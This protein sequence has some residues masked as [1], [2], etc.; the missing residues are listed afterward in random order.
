MSKPATHSHRSFRPVKVV[1]HPL[2]EIP[3]DPDRMC[4]RKHR[5]HDKKDAVTAINAFEKGRARER[6]GRPEWLREYHC[7]ICN[8]W[9]LT[10]GKRK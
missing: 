2:G 3:I 6:H 7:P 10:K 9:H 1:I 4:N 8:F 5:Y